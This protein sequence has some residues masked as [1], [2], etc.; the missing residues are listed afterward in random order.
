[1]FEDLEAK[2]SVMIH[3]VKATRTPT[4]ISITGAR[5][6]MIVPSVFSIMAG[7]IVEILFMLFSVCNGLK[8]SEYEVYWLMDFPRIIY[9]A[10]DKK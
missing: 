9:W 8:I 7:L 10:R 6:L 5:T 3:R 4:F 1:M 2:R